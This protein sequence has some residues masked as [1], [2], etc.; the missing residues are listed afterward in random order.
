[1]FFQGWGSR[2]PDAKPKIALFW[3]YTCSLDYLIG[4]SRQPCEEGSVF[5]ILC[6]C[7]SHV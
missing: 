7:F 2:G 6:C 4:P 1:M 3:T 5:P